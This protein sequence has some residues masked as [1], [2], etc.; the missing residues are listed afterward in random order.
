LLTPP[1]AGIRL[2]DCGVKSDTNKSYCMLCVIMYDAVYC[3]F[4]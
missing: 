1:D 3:Q 4:L 2:E